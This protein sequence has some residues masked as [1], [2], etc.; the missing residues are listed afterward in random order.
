MKLIAFHL[1]RRR[2]LIFGHGNCRVERTDGSMNSKFAR[3]SKHLQNGGTD[4]CRC[5]YTAMPIQTFIRLR[6]YEEE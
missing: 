5:D 4:K 1:H 3:A 2:A 6:M